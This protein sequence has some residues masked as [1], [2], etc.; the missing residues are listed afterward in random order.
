MCTL[1]ATCV[2]LRSLECIPIQSVTNWSYVVLYI[3]NENVLCFYANLLCSIMFEQPIEHLRLTLSHSVIL[4]RNMH[5][6]GLNNVV[7]YALVQYDK[8]IG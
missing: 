8:I 7:T 1:V 3:I 5:Y 6:L 2:I 4:N